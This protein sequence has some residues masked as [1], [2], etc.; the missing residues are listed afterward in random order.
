M[1]VLN[2]SG[3]G[4]VGGTKDGG[5]KQY[6]PFRLFYNFPLNIDLSTRA[7][8]RE[9]N[10]KKYPS[11]TTNLSISILDSDRRRKAS[12]LLSVEDW[13]RWVLTVGELLARVKEIYVD[14]R[15]SENINE[16]DFKIVSYRGEVLQMIPV[17]ARIENESVPAVR[18]VFNDPAM[19]VD[20]PLV[21]IKSMHNV[22]SRIDVVTMS[23]C[24]NLLGDHL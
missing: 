3:S 1:A 14:N 13:Y 6:Y 5:E 2:Y 19:F 24:A 7:I 9:I 12:V 18:I 20:F 8:S 16:D 4:G 22:V 23:I 15:I 17:V 11:V 10:G 21:D